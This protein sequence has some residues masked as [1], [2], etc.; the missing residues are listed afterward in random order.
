MEN[1]KMNDE[2]K[3]KL[4]EMTQNYL[5]PCPLIVWGSGAT[6]PFGMPS[7]GE[8]KQEIEITKEGNLEKILS[9]IKNKKTK[10]NYE[11]KIFQIINERDSNL[12]EKFIKNHQEIKSLFNF[13]NYF[14]NSHPQR[15][16]IITTNYDCVLEYMFSYYGIPYSD[17]FSGREFSEFNEKMFKDKNQVNL[18]KVHGSLRWHKAR[19]SHHNSMMDGIFPTREKY[20]KAHLDPYRTIITKSDEAIKR[21]KCFLFIGFGFNDQHITSEIEKLLDKGIVSFGSR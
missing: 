11:R 1:K 18:Y 5:N 15:V 12:R 10:S 19:Y 9:N 3:N 20:E 4:F 13:I 16:D 8:L 14:Y 2:I 7:M 17:G 6:I 21:A